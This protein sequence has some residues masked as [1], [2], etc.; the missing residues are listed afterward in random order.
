MKRSLTDPS[1]PAVS[2]KNYHSFKKTK[3]HRRYRLDKN[4]AIHRASATRGHSLANEV[5]Q[6]PAKMRTGLNPILPSAISRCGE[7]PAALALRRNGSAGPTRLRTKR[8]TAPR[9]SDRRSPRRGGDRARHVPQRTVFTCGLTLLVA[10][11]RSCRR[12]P[13]PGAADLDR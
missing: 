9:V 10:G 7:C 3:I 5:R 12:P 6:N 2:W 11:A 1:Y 13:S 4:I 8:L